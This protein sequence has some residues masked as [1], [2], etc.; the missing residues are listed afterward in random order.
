MAS[1]FVCFM[2]ALLLVVAFTCGYDVLGG[3][4]GSTD[5]STQ[6]SELFVRIAI[7]SLVFITAFGFS[8]GVILTISRFKQDKRNILIPI[9]YIVMPVLLMFITFFF[10]MML[11]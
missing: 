1:V 4:A 6:I 3:V 10:G 8:G 7:I 9:L 5:N 2:P 11:N